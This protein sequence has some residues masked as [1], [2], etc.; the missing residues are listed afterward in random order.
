MDNREKYL[1]LLCFPDLYPFGVN[2]QHETRQVK[3]YDYEFVKCRF[4]SKHPQY[5]L[6]QQYLFYLLND[7]NIRQLNRGIYH[8][9]NVT[10]LR[11]RYTAAEYLK[12]M[13]EELLEL[14]ESNLNTIFSTLRNTEQYW[15]RSRKDLSCMT[16][17]NGPAT[18]FLTLS[19]AGCG[20]N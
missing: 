9:L 5:R 3:F 7:A 20:M 16:Q 17:H 13:S 12:A 18:W 1:D 10:N 8:K 2:E 19:P 6:N 15:Y 14:L 11:D 4:I